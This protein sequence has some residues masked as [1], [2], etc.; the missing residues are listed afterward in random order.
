M[1]QLWDSV[2]LCENQQGWQNW[3]LGLSL[4]CTK[5]I[6]SQGHVV[7]AECTGLHCSGWRE[8]LIGVYPMRP[9]LLQDC[10][11][12]HRAQVLLEAPGLGMALITIILHCAESFLALAIPPINS[13]RTESLGLYVMT[14][15]LETLHLRVQMDLRCFADML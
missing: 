1:R 2:Q 5:R 14:L 12:K 3:L 11:C 13:K 10:P 6:S 4:L 7:S 15:S 9:V 8:T